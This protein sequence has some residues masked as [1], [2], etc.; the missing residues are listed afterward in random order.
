MVS[1]AH[2]QKLHRNLAL[3]G[4]I[5]GEK[6]KVTDGTFSVALEFANPHPVSVRRSSRRHG[7]KTDAS[8]LF[9]KGIDT[10]ARFRALITEIE[11]DIREW[12]KAGEARE[13]RHSKA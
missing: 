2:G 9:E 6:S 5:G 12:N 7:R 13:A 3:L 11:D 10:A 8:F 4:V 1:G